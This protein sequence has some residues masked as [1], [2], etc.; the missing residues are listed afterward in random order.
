MLALKDKYRYRLLVDETYSFGVL[1][2]RGRGACEHFGLRPQEDV[3]IVV[4]SM[5]S[6][7]GTV[8]GFCAASHVIVDHQR[9][10]GAGYCFSASLPPFLASAGIAVLD[11]LEG[12]L[13]RGGNVLGGRAVEQARALRGLLGAGDVKGL[14]ARRMHFA[15]CP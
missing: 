10:S 13:G 11:K 15:P 6:A 5:S 9:L 4:A 12:G 8:G 14:R 2:A 7:L 3:D 1:G